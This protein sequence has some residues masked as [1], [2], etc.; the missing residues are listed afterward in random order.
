LLR[1]PAV[2]PATILGLIAAAIASLSI[3]AARP[4][5]WLAALADNVIWVDGACLRGHARRRGH[6]VRN[7]GVVVRWALPR[8]SCASSSAASGTYRREIL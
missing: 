4:M 2:A 6:L 8:R 1:G 5:V 3:A 7:V